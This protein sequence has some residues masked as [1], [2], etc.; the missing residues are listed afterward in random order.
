MWSFRAVACCVISGQ[1]E[2]EMD[3]WESDDDGYTAC[4]V[5]HT[6]SP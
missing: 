6:D 5:G 1:S 3:S 2:V 4:Q